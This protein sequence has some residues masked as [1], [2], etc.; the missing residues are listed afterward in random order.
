MGLLNT[1]ERDVWKGWQFLQMVP[2]TTIYE[3]RKKKLNGKS[4]SRVK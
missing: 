1:E 4:H 3:R 2:G